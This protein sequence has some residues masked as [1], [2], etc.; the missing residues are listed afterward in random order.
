MWKVSRIF[1]QI[2]QILSYIHN[3][4]Q[5]RYKVCAQVSHC[6]NKKK[7]VQTNMISFVS[8][9]SRNIIFRLYDFLFNTIQIDL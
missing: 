9:A 8:L 6:V 3:V 1:Q 7:I 2:R 5:G 4:K